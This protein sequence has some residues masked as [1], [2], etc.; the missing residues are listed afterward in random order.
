MEKLSEEIVGLIGKGKSKY[1]AF[2]EMEPIE[3]LRSGMQDFDFFY[4]NSH[5]SPILW[6]HLFFNQVMKEREKDLMTNKLHTFR[7][8]HKEMSVT[9][10]GIRGM[11]TL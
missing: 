11:K 9:M 2:A 10:N 1:A 8:A 4:P 6:M 5:S 3:K 7:E